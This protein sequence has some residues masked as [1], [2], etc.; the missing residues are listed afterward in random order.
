M[1]NISRVI[2]YKKQVKRQMIEKPKPVGID[3]EEE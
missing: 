3:R 1:I 2:R